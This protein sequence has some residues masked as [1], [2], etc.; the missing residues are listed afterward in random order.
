MHK[1]AVW[2]YFLYTLGII[3]FIYTC[4]TGWKLWQFYRLTERATPQEINWSIYQPSDD[5]Y[6]M[7]ADYSFESRGKQYKDRYILPEPKLYNIYAAEQVQKEVS[8]KKWNVWFAK[9]DEKHSQ[10]IKKF[11]MKECIYTLI[12]W[13]LLIY[14]I[15]LGFYV[16]KQQH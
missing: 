6:R 16:S 4:F 8:Q 9:N 14:F 12:L 5:E 13:G 1:N 10:L 11:P 15:L 2:L 3:V 7:Q